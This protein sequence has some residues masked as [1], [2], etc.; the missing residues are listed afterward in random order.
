MID[1]PR[2]LLYVAAAL[3]PRNELPERMEGLIRPF[4]AE[5]HSNDLFGAA[6]TRRRYQ[7]HQPL[8]R[9]LLEHHAGPFVPAELKSPAA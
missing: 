4:A 8:F 2:G 6:Q 9:S 3:N 5:G 7:H 1:W